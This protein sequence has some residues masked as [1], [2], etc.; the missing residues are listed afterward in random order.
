MFK[1]IEPEVACGLGEKTQMDS[2]VHPPIVSKLHFVFEDWLGDDIIKPF[3]A[4]SLLNH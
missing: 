1:Y 4:T 3:R 2:S